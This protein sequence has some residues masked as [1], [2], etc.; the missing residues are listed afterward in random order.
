MLMLV[1][2]GCT[3]SPAGPTAESSASTPRTLDQSIVS[4]AIDDYLSRGSLPLQNVRAVLVS[5]DGDNQVAHYRAGGPTDRAHVFSVTKSVLSALVGIALDDGILGSLDDDLRMLL[6]EY[7]QEMSADVSAITLEQLVTM[8]SGLPDDTLEEDPRLERPDWVR[9]I[10][11]DGT[12]AEPGTTWIYSNPAAD[13]LAAVLTEALRRHDGHHART[14]LDYARE[15]LFDPLGIS[16]RPAYTGFEG[17]EPWSARFNDTSF[18]WATDHRGRHYG[19][20]MLK[21]TA[22]DMMKFGELFR[23]GGRWD[24]RQIVPEEWV[25][26]STTPNRNASE[27]GRLWWIVTMGTH[28]TYFADGRAGQ[29]IA[30]IPDLRTT[31]VVSSLLDVVDQT[32]TRVRGADLLPMINDVIV[33]R[34]E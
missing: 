18:G 34:L 5:V 3:A 16:T 17:N 11:R 19:C 24:G 4:T 2:L 12:V 21:L 8:S 25:T 9:E 33:S 15:K 1:A 7:R 13:V 20:C 32:N 29:L 31:V 27:Y 14:I 23:L 26:A 10:I 22:E 30:V 28:P 6:P